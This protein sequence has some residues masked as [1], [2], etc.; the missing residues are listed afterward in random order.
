MMTLAL[1]IR[2]LSE[3]DVTGSFSAGAE[4]DHVKLNEFFARY[5]KQNQRRTLSA[6][7]VACAD[8][9]IAGFVTIVGGTIDPTD[10]PDHAKGLGRYSQPVLIVARMA[11]D[12]RFQ[13]QGVGDRLMREVVF[14]EAM[15]MG[16]RLGC[17]GVYVDPKPGAVTFYQR[18]GFAA[19]PKPE[20]TEQTRM[21]LPL[22]TIRSA[23]SHRSHVVASVPMT[24]VAPAPSDAL[25]NE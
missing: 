7:H 25:R 22:Q 16:E 8:G 17:L 23:A 12:A 20:A 19:L 13:R 2:R 4:P 1:E 10:I 9:V 3:R 24:L 14:A 18:Y 21:F 15:W 11:T 6:T 5:A